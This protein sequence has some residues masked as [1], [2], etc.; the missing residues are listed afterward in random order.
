[1]SE[2]YPIVWIEHI[3]FILPADGHL[4]C[5]YFSA[6]INYAAVNICV[7]VSVWHIISF[8]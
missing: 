8:L 4:Y 1:M 7:Q 5:F 2:Y 6:I 3:L